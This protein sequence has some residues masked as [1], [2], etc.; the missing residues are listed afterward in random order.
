MPGYDPTHRAPR[1]P[2]RIPGLGWVLGAASVLAVIGLVMGAMTYFGGDPGA[3][4]EQTPSRAE[5][6]PAGE[7]ETV[8]AAAS[9]P[10]VDPDEPTSWGPTVGE[11]AQAQELVAG[12]DA[13]RLAGQVIIGRYDGYDP[14]TPA[15][16]VRDL[17]LAGVTLTNS[18]VEDAEQVTATTSAV[19][20]AMTADGR[21]FPPLIG[22]DQEGG[23]V[24][25]LGDVATTYPSFQQAG[26]VITAAPVEGRRLVTEA[27]RASG[28]ELRQLG[29]T[30]VYAPVA[31]VTIGYGD[32][33]IGSRSASTDPDVAADAVVAALEGF[34]SAGVVTST[35]H[36]PGHGSATEDSHAVV[37]EVTA[38]LEELR[39]RDLVPFAA[40]VDAGAPAVMLGHLGVDAIAPGEP[41]SMAPAAYDFL[42]DEL[43]FEGVTMTDSLGMGA[44]YGRNRP[45]LT[46]F[47]AGADLLLMPADTATA[48]ATITA[49]IE[50]GEIS[51][52]RAEESAARVVAIQLW[53]QRI[54][55]EVAVPLDA[56]T[57]AEAAAAAL[58]AAAP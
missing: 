4:D 51:R 1:P 52:E 40:A 31:D 9:D 27:T 55:A 46:A 50:S 45:A 35:K 16:L 56:T 12:W 21:T 15:A 26:D 3:A 5:G 37:P 47:L 44:V 30:W 20:D 8:G 57:Q 54:A 38:T 39:A 36:F 24:A 28:L 33:T 6:D 10:E 18:N 58:V 17:H 43:G 48:H 11:L 41:A 53:Q 23:L 19:A 42:R 49:A 32:V 14:E 34:S 29:F 7:R 13:E 2:R 25:H 22:V